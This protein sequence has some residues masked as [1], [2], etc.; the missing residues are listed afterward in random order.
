[1]AEMKFEIIF[2]ILYIYLCAETDAGVRFYGVKRKI[3]SIICLLF[4]AG[5]FHNECKKGHMHAQYIFFSK[6][7]LYTSQI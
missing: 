1:M 6:C 7:H 5:T 3:F 4:N 2:G